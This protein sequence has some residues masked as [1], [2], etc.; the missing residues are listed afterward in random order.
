[1]DC[2]LDLALRQ[3]LKQFSLAGETQERERV[4][5]HFSKRYCDCNPGIYNSEGKNVVI[6]I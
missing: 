6:L 5:A 1:M 3:F 2:T 4:L